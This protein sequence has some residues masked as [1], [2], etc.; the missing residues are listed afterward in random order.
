MGN[1]LITRPNYA[2]DS[3]GQGKNCKQSFSRLQT[4]AQAR[5]KKGAPPDTY[6]M[7]YRF[8]PRIQWF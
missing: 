7:L 2:L 5:D 1:I 4:Q 8:L 6:E 3:C